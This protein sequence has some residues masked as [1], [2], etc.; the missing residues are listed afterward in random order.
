MKTD[1]WLD[2]CYGF[3]E[4]F[5]RVRLGWKWNFVDKQGNFLSSEWFDGGISFNGGFARVK[6][7][8]ELFY[9]DKEGGLHVHR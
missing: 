5:G 7:G 4:G 1:N 3:R 2:D 9:I 6:L 8:K